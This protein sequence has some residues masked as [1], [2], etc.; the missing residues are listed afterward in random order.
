MC[1]HDTVVRV[2]VSLDGGVGQCWLLVK[3]Y[4]FVVFEEL[5][6]LWRTEVLWSLTLFITKETNGCIYLNGYG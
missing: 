2:S 6:D 3:H 5:H 1:T 4:T